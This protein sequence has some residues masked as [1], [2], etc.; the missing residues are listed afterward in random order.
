MELLFQIEFGYYIVIFVIS[1]GLVEAVSTKYIGSIPES[2]ESYFLLPL[3]VVN[4]A[5]T[6]LSPIYFLLTIFFSESD[7]LAFVLYIGAN[8]SYPMLL[9]SYKKEA[10]MIYMQSL[11]VSI[12]CTLLMILAAVLK[13]IF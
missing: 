6:L 5:L 1:L 3:F 4:Y 10:A 13:A 12:P 11:M 2:I 9:M 8:I 7:W